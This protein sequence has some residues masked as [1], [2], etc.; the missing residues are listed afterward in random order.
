MAERCESLHTRPHT[1]VCAVAEGTNVIAAAAA[2]LNGA[3]EF[4]VSRLFS[5]SAP[6]ER[7]DDQWVGVVV[8]SNQ[9]H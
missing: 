6:R 1:S 2:I 8:R 7:L 3:N 9:G 4:E 5:A